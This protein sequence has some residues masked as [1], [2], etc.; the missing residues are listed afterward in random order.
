VD[1]SPVQEFYRTG[2]SGF[3]LVIKALELRPMYGAKSRMLESHEHP[4]KSTADYQHFMMEIVWKGTKR[5]H[6][7]IRDLLM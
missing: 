4:C 2:G 7:E 6:L 3:L 1:R 5:L